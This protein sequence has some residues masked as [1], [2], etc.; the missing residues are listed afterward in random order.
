MLDYDVFVI[1]DSKLD[2]N[3]NYSIKLVTTRDLHNTQLLDKF[4]ELNIKVDKEFTGSVTKVVYYT[5]VSCLVDIKQWLLRL[6]FVL[7][8]LGLKSNLE[9]IRK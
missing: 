9:K 4:N 2:T 5:D 3:Y 7:D 6:N 8:Q 1:V